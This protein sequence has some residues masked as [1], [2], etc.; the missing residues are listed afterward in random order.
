MFSMV[1]TQKGFKAIHFQENFY[2]IQKKNKNGTDRW[3]CTN[4]LCSSSIII[5]NG[6]IQIVKGRHNHNN[7]KRSTSIVKII[8]TI[9]QEVCENPSKPVSQIY[10][11]AI[12][13]YVCVIFV[14]AFVKLNK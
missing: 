13:T 1:T 9:R 2:R 4:R 10:N 11:E 5:K 7:V 8:H 3:V 12:S 6:T 14:F